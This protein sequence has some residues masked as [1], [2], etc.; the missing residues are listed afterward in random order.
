[1]G[2][3]MG[4]KGIY[5]RIEGEDE[6]HYSKHGRRSGRLRDE[7][8]S[9][10]DPE[11]YN[12]HRVEHGWPPTWDGIIDVPP[13]GPPPRD[14]SG[15]YWKIAGTDQVYFSKSRKRIR[16]NKAFEDPDDFFHHRR[17][18]GWP[19]DWSEIE[20]LEEDCYEGTDVCKYW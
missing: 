3:N 18:H 9:F 5:W 13:P 4:K 20:E 17:K 6:V 16:A 19:E 11:A 7:G 8:V 12:E 10:P 14:H 1:M 15:L 2:L